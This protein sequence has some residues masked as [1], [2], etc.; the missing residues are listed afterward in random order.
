[1]GQAPSRNSATNSA[2]L[3]A[4]AHACSF[5]LALAA[6]LGATALRTGEILISAA[7]TLQPLATG[8]TIT[9]IHL[10]VIARLPHLSQ[11]DFID[12]TV[13]AKLN[14]LVSRA[15]RPSVSMNAKLEKEPPGPLGRTSCT[16][17]PTTRRRARGRQ[18]RNP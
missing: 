17:I 14:C 8:W 1:L 7:V 5:S 15:L 3:I 9:N 13:R 4:A 10:G 2:E 18:T 16:K 6:E 12:A 11:G